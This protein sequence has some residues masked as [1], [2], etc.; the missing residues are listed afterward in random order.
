MIN[1]GA[2]FTMSL[3]EHIITLNKINCKQEDGYHQIKEI[4]L[5]NKLKA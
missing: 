4:K 2:I 3:L 5:L 1:S